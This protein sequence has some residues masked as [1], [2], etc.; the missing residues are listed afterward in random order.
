MQ[1]ETQRSTENKEDK[2]AAKETA[3]PPDRPPVSRPADGMLVE[4]EP[5]RSQAKGIK[6]YLL[7]YMSQGLKVKGYLAVPEDAVPGPGLLYCRGGIRKV[8]MVRKR[9]IFSMARRGY[10]VFAPF[11]RGNEGGEGR[12]DF[13]G[14]DRFDVRHAVKLMQSLPEMVP[15]PVPLIGFSRGAIMAMQAAK[16]CPEVV[17]PVV[18][19]GGVSDLFDTYEERVD[20][21]R[22]LKRV[23]GHPRKQADAYEQRSPVYWVEQVKVPVM[24]VHGMND[25]QVSVS[26]ARKLAEALEREGKDYAMELYE[27]LEHRFPKEDDERALDAV[28]AWITRKQEEMKHS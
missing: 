21:R 3:A 22:M 2:L 17:G 9:R 7:T 5:L 16:E 1:T 12:E 23:V 28:F 18:V 11:Y 13:G 8:G 4:R 10:V 14:E 6:L 20:L 15:G 27:G 26:H 24:I 25:M 19:W